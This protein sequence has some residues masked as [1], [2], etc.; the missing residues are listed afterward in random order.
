MMLFL[1]QLVP[2]LPAAQQ[3][4]DAKKAI[5]A[6]LAIPSWAINHCLY[7]PLTL[8]LLL[9]TF[10]RARFT[11]TTPMT[12]WLRTRYTGATHAVANIIS[13]ILW[14]SN[15]TNARI[16]WQWSSTMR[17]RT[18]QASMRNSSMT[19]WAFC[20]ICSGTNHKIKFGLSWLSQTLSAISLVSF[21]FVRIFL[22]LYELSS[23]GQSCSP[24]LTSKRWHEQSRGIEWYCCLP[25]SYGRG[26]HSVG[27]LFCVKR[28]PA[29]LPLCTTWAA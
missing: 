22:F 10:V 27:D 18:S 7:F 23:R 5:A 8:L 17:Y 24:S 21:S 9:W 13:T 25:Y 1:T 15:G 16:S 4:T 6:P 28:N 12:R 26:V 14:R 29:M 19:H 2:V 3:T 11:A 20:F